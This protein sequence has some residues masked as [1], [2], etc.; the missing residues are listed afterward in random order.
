[1][2][3]IE[4]YARGNDTSAWFDD[5]ACTVTADESREMT[6]STEPEQLNRVGYRLSQRDLNNS[7][8][9]RFC[10]EFSLIRSLNF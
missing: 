7:H 1:M 5:M 10:V 3:Y 8:N 6:E 9:Q 2:K 4:Q